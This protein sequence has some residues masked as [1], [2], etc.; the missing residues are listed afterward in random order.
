MCG[1]AGLWNLPD[2]AGDPAPSARQ[3]ATVQAMMDALSHRGPDASGQHTGPRG[4]IGHRRLS[5]VDLT[6][7][8]QPIRAPGTDLVLV[9]NGE[10][11]S[12]PEQ[13][14]Q[15]AHREFATGNDNE[16]ALHLYAEHGLDGLLELDGMYAFAIADGDELIL[17][18]D[19]V[20]IK[21]LYTGRFDGAMIF[22]SELK[23]LPPGTTDVEVFPPGATWS[24]ATGWGPTHQLP[25]PEITDRDLDAH[26]AHVR[27]VLE[28][29]VVKRLMA[30]V[31]VGAFV[32][33]G[34]DSSA[35]AALTAEHVDEL[36]T[37]SVGVENSPDVVA[38]RR[39]A[40][41]LGSIHHEHL[42][43]RQQIREALPRVIAS[44]ESF[45]QDLVRHA[46]PNDFIAQLAVQ[47][48][49]VVLTGSGADEVFAGYRYYEDYT[50]E[51]LAAEL[52]RSVAGLHDINIKRVDR[53]TMAHGLEAR[54]PFLDLE[55]IEAGLSTPPRWVQ[56]SDDRPEKWL[57]RKAVEDLLPD[58]IVWRGKEQFGDGAGASAL[59][60]EVAAEVVGS[61]AID[62]VRREYPDTPVRSAEE[63]AYLR[64]LVDEVDNPELI[65]GNI[66]RWQSDRRGQEIGGGDDTPEPT[67]AAA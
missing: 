9:G 18:R 21:P 45:D 8:D 31:P 58:E 11:Y 56:A 17:H 35:V 28:R 62:R 19:P 41:H 42:L 51:E 43:T 37:F 33:G 39:V 24:S 20:G 27:E 47:H 66:T 4:V 50:P 60:D 15:L 64:M 53:L 61:T 44:V 3:R 2:T 13:R 23:A 40:E 54:V 67:P 52:R 1:I 14:R 38:A 34:L 55:V 57:L 63:A 30:D 16:V 46:V 32:S 48:V 22:C 26:T 10:V 7:G 6:G 36:H 29:A 59:L 5:I 12:A 49:K 25:D 65:L